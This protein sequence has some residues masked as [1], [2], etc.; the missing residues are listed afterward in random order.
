MLSD[1]LVEKL[2]SYKNS[3]LMLLLLFREE[4]LKNRDGFYDKTV[5]SVCLIDIFPLHRSSYFPVAPVRRHFYS[6]IFF[7]CTFNTIHFDI[8]TIVKIAL[9]ATG[10]VWLGKK[11]GTYIIIHNDTKVFLIHINLQNIT[12]ILILMFLY[13]II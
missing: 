6:I 12:N 3:M 8:T 9:T 11:V 2:S 13:L 7:M 4:V 1:C 10:R 5:N